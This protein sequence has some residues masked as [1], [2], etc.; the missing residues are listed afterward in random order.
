MPEVDN[1]TEMGQRVFE[2]AIDIWIKPEVERRQA[3]GVLPPNFDLHAAQVIFSSPADRT[4]NT[5]RLNEE[6]TAVFLYRADRPINKGEMIS[7]TNV[8]QIEGMRLPEGEDANAA[9]LT[10]MRIGSDWFVGFDF[11]Y[12]RGRSYEHL[13]AAEEFLQ[14]AGL[15]LDNRLYRP[16]VENLFAATELAAEAEML[17]LPRERTKKHP[18][19]AKRFH[20]WVRFQNAPEEADSAL[21][22]LTGL[23]GTARYLES[24]FRCAVEQLKQ[25]YDAAASLIQHVSR[26]LERHKRRDVDDYAI[27]TL[28][29]L[30]AD[31]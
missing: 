9:H 19:R 6:V 17:L 26:R 7:I 1:E 15:C 5:V 8:D 14:A 2:Q 23:R 28:E 20:E 30:K 13:Q 18:E 27:R 21:R 31:G 4:G 12:N 16:A 24:D 29:Y 25:Y 10:V 22:K 3:R 11:T